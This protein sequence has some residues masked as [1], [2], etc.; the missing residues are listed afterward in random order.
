MGE[1]ID[2]VAYKILFSGIVQG[3]G[4]RFTARRIAAKFG[5]T[6]YVKNLIDGKVEVWAE[7]AEQEI[8]R[9]VEAIERSFSGY[10]SE[11]EKTEVSPSEKFSCFE[12]AF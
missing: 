10:I 11:V 12:I 3:V 2:I 8:E 5:V 4:F 7:G 1:N 6:G 9:F